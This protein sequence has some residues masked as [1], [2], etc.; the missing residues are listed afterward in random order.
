MARQVEWFFG[1]GLLFSW[2]APQ[3]VNAAAVQSGIEVN[4]ELCDGSLESTRTCQGPLESTVLFPRLPAKPMARHVANRS[5]RFGYAQLSTKGAAPVHAYVFHHR[6]EEL[7]GT[8]EIGH[9]LP[10]TNSHSKRGVM[11]S[12]S[13]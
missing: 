5:R 10:G 3:P 8:Y 12:L 1:L 9:R 7:A 13:I 4:W 6:V 2:A 11:Q